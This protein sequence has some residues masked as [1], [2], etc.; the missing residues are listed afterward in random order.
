MTHKVIQEFTPIIPAK[1]LD[2]KILLDLQYG[3]YEQYDNITIVSQFLKPEDRKLNFHAD[4][5]M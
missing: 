1:S 3:R 4:L 5:Q 2:L